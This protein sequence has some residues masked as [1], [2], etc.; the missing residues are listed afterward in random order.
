MA[1]LANKVAIITGAARGIGAACAQRFAQE[2][3]AVAV[4]D[5]DQHGAVLAQQLAAKGA[6]AIFYRCDVT[7]ADEI[8]RAVADV[9]AELGPPTVLVN[10]AGISISG[11]VEEISEAQWD[12]QFAVNV[13]S[14]FL[15]SRRVLP[16]MRT[17]GGG[18]IVNMASESAFAGFPQ[19]PAYCASK[20][21]VV[22]LSRSMA[23]RYAGEKIRV[24]ALCP[25][26]I[27]TDLY[28]A[29]LT[30]QPDP[31]ATHAEVLRQHPLG[32]GQPDDIAW[33]A[34]Y[35]ASDESRYMTGSP[36]LVD[37]GMLAI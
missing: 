27:D 29:F 3:A 26:T 4:L 25:G 5:I 19:H 10:N 18:S 24:N 6:S 15:V 28:R 7:R 14:I 17:A 35:M 30:Q 31:D 32:I 2:G 34:V 23:M 33:A 21:A 36:L 12:R 8:D 16:H 13:K 22:H 37:G 20:A 1:R 11:G 9:A